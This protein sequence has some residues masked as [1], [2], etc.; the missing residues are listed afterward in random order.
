MIHAS[1][2][3]QRSWA[4]L[5]SGVTAAA[6]AAVRAA[7]LAGGVACKACQGCALLVQHA[8][9]L[10]AKLAAPPFLAGFAAAVVLL[11]LGS[12]AWLDAAP[13]GFLWEAEPMAV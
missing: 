2:L 13:L 1:M 12:K 9:A 11:A 3:A 4:T 8:H 6:R 10:P 5:Q 7:A